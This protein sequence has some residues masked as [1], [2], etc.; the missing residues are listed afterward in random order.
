M[1]ILSL[2]Q[3]RIVEIRPLMIKLVWNHTVHVTDF[4]S[5]TASLLREIV[6]I[7]IITF[8]I[9]QIYMFRCAL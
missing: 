2:D 8:S 9:A 6:V 7:I 1:N 5:Q 3:K 4:H